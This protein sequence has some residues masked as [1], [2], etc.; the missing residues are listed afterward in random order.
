MQDR[1]TSQGQMEETLRTWG[2]KL[3]TMKTKADQAGADR[4]VELDQKIQALTAQRDAM[5]KKLAD[6]KASSDDAWES[7]KIG[8]E[9]AWHRLNHA[10][11][12]AMSKF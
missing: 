10:F 7:M 8:M 2:E 4:K 5:Q 3:D 1:Q 6:L 12:E 9:G 11:E